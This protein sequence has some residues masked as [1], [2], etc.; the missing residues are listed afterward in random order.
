MSATLTDLQSLPAPNLLQPVDHSAA[1]AA[2]LDRLVALLAEAGIP[3]D[4]ESLK[5]DP[6]VITEEA[7]AYRDTLQAQAINDAA[8]QLLVAFARGTNLDHRGA[9]VST[10][11]LPDE[12]D[13]HYRERIA[14][15]LERPSTAG[16]AAGYREHAK[17]ADADVFDV[18]I[19]RP[20][21]PR[22]RVYVLGYAGAPSSATLAAVTAAVSTEDVRP[23]NDVVEVLAADVVAITV[24]GTYDLYPG[25]DAGSVKAAGDAGI[26]AYFAR[27]F[28]LGHDIT[29]PGVI[30][31]GTVAGV[32]SFRPLLDGSTQDIVLDGTQAPIL[33]TLATTVSPIRDV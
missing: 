12:T 1:L 6:L 26:A 3:F 7:G 23:M 16:S 32:K 13:D 18:A 22:V 27:H 31:A 14:N 4:V 15:A 28:A 11:R 17:A 30:A 21:P 20:G 29:L 24:T 5:T 2:R 9:G 33:G 10:P 8:R 19:V 25:A